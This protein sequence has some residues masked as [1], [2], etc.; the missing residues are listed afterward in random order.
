MA[1]DQRK[2]PW[3]SPGD[4]TIDDTLSLNGQ[5]IAL[6]YVV[7]RML[8]VGDQNYRAAVAERIEYDLG[9]NMWFEHM[10][11]VEKRAA[12]ALIRQIFQPDHGSPQDLKNP[13]DGEL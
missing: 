4:P 5:L 10:H 11:P 12:D 7:K 8:D 9:T 1:L 3:D 2:E 13:L 6:T